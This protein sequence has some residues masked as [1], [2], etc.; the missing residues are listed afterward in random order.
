MSPT[1]ATAFSSIYRTGLGSHTAVRTFAER[2]GYDTVW[3]WWI[4]AIV[5]YAGL[6]ATEIGMVMIEN[7]AL[8]YF[9]LET[10]FWNLEA[11]SKHDNAKVT[12]DLRNCLVDDLLV[13]RN[14]PQVY[15]G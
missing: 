11:S 14:L 12:D 15:P 1:L 7:L 13:M 6:F 9:L 8:G 10:G 2:N 3:L 4:G 5:A